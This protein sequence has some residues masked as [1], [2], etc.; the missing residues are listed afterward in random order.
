MAFNILIN[1]IIGAF[2]H[3]LIYLV[4]DIGQFLLNLFK[5]IR[6][7]LHLLKSIHVSIF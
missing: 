3:H 7:R 2:S 5:I 1:D 4:I 6:H